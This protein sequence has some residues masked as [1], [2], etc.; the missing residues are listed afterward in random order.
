[1]HL[2]PALKRRI[3][4]KSFHCCQLSFF[5]FV[6]LF[7]VFCCLLLPRMAHGLRQVCKNGHCCLKVADL[8]Q[9]WSYDFSFHS[10]YGQTCSLF[11]KRRRGSAERR[12]NS[13]AEVALS[14]TRSIAQVVF[15][16]I[17]MISSLVKVYAK[18][19]CLMFL[20]SSSSKKEA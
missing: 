7:N 3:L 17:Q 14:R 9:N 5:L 12:R 10:I 6:C 19:M 15:K 2:L 18:I 1:M 16:K 4:S 11:P 20:T 8:P 13:Y